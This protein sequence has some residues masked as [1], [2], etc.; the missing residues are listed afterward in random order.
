MRNLKTYVPIKLLPPAFATWRRLPRHC[1][2]ELMVIRQLTTP[3]LKRRS[4]T[5]R[6]NAIASASRRRNRT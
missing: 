3:Q 1:P 2:L 5:R 6:R 4:R